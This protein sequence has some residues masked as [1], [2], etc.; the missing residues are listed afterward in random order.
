MRVLIFLI[1]C[2]TPILSSGQTRTVKGKVIG[3]YE[4]SP[5]PGVKIEN[6]DTIQLGM[7]DRQGNFKIELPTGTTQLTFSLIGMERT[8]VTVPTNCDN[9]EI[10]IMADVIYDFVT[11]ETVDRRRY[12]RFKKF[13]IRHREA[14]KNGIFTTREPC[15]TYIYQK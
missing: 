2:V 14:F 10:I 7:T 15:V 5:I 8:S 11:I 9:L 6:G 13:N 1:I 12:K 4:V 3:E